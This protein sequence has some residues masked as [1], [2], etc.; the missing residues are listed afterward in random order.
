MSESGFQSIST[1][2]VDPADRLDYWVYGTGH[3]INLH[4]TTVHQR[5]DFHGRFSW[6]EFPEFR[7]SV[8]DS[9][10]QTTVAR[11]RHIE[12]DCNRWYLAAFLV[13]GRCQ[14]ESMGKS[15]S[16]RAGQWILAD[17]RHPRS[18]A[19][20]GAFRVILAGLPMTTAELLMPT[21]LRDAAL[22]TPLAGDGALGIVSTFFR[23]LVDLGVNDPASA[24]V[25]AN[26]GPA[27][28]AAGASLA[29]ATSLSDVAEGALVRESVLG[30][31]HANFGDP[32]LDVATIA[33]ACNVSRRTL[34]RVFSGEGE[35]T[36]GQILRQ[37]RVERAKA[38]L[39]THR[40]RSVHAIGEACGFGGERQFHRVFRA[41]TSMSPAEFRERASRDR[42]VSTASRTASLP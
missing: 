4:H 40:H 20:D 22:A 7:L 34:Y 33:R 19:Y 29:S 30:F 38:M 6:M 21:R 35:Q 25:L 17:S 5:E 31:I 23:S 42:A 32:A 18:I 2:S 8:L 14:Y 36:V 3:V 41:Q 39:A 12:G 28:L 27:L 1:D 13:A 24:R 26:Q 10:S 15:V 16:L 9:V 37:V 11:R